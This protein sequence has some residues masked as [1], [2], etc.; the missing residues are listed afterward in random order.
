M[1]NL[2]KESFSDSQ[3]KTYGLMELVK[4][5][6]PM[7]GKGPENTV[8][9]WPNLLI[10]EILVAL[11]TLVL[12]VLWSLA[13]DA[14]LREMANP[15]LTENPAKAPW[16]FLNLQELLLHMHP[17]L[18]GV[19]LP[20][21]VII[22]LM[23]IPYVDKSKTD[24]GAWFASSKGKKIALVSAIYTTLW[25]PTLI[26]FDEF[27]RV[28]TI[29]KEPEIIPG[30]I[31][32]LGVMGMLVAILYFIIKRWRPSGREVLIGLFTGFAVSYLVMTISGTFFRGLG[33]HL[34]LPWNLPPG[35]LSF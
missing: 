24:M 1:Q 7:V 26:L 32:P 30:W 9:S 10:L 3:G 17:S 12:L 18:A 19:F 6:S 34:T 14:P 31:I 4:G 25:I 13:V 23:A 2:N 28:R 29:I 16:Y 22:A 21:A 15:D 11:G 35:A 8:M 27:V 33:M 20:G 5:T